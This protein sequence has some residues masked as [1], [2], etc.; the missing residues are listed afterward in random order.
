MKGEQIIA[1]SI[2]A[3][4][5]TIAGR[6]PNTIEKPPAR[7]SAPPVRCS[8][9]LTGVRAPISTSTGASSEP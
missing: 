3:P 6:C 9:S 7:M 1:V 5:T 4:S 8:A 2:R